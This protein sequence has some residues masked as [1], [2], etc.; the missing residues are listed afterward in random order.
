MSSPTDA[1][2]TPPMEPTSDPVAFAAS[3]YGFPDTIL[4]VDPATR[5][6]NIPIAAVYQTM[7]LQR[8]ERVPSLCMLFL[9]GRCR[10]QT[11]CHQLHVD[12]GVVNMLRS[13]IL[14]RP[15]CCAMHGEDSVHASITE[16]AP[17]L[18]HVLFES[19]SVPADRIAT[20]QGIR[21]A[22]A[23]KHST[24]RDTLQLPRS[25]L[26]R[27]QVA[28]RCRY[29]ED[30]NF[31]HVCRYLTDGSVDHPI[32]ALAQSTEQNTPTKGGRWSNNNASGSTRG[33]P[34]YS[35]NASGFLPPPSPLYG[36]SAPPAYHRTMFGPASTD[37]SFSENLSRSSDS[38]PPSTPNAMSTPM[39]S[40]YKHEPYNWNC[41][42][43]LEARE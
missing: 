33:S 27:L 14:A 41:I 10:A 43:P 16:Q 32:M 42:P 21:K 3:G 26:C 20:T 30:C 40:P 28:G 15:A 22:I 8:R 2:N 37:N 38:T 19:V 36:P 9:Q 4:A 34:T 12:P 29:A 7:A 35:N 11:A 39:T 18:K 31:V 5:K 17:T 23:E 13:E 1:P 24:D 6:L 25:S